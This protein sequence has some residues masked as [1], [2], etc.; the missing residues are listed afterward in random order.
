MESGNTA[1][2]TTKKLIS[3]K[4]FTKKEKLRLEQS[5]FYGLYCRGYGIS[6]KELETHW[7]DDY[8]ENKVEFKEAVANSDN[9]ILFLEIKK[10]LKD[11]KEILFGSEELEERKTE[12]VDEAMLDENDNILSKRETEDSIEKEKD[13]IKDITIDKMEVVVGEKC[14]IEVLPKYENG[15]LYRFYIKRYEDWDIVRDYDISNIL[16]YTATEAGEKEFLIQYCNQQVEHQI[17]WA[18]IG[19]VF[20]AS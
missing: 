16:K 6:R 19:W 11:E 15:C 7:N 4:V 3:N 2:I 17:T 14:S 9:N 5:L 10:L 12:I 20:Q 18:K 1:N 13:L 8:N